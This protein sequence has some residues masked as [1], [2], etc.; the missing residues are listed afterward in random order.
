MPEIA[1]PKELFLHELG[2]IL[3]VERALAEK[4][5]PKLIGEVQDSEFKSGL[6]KH[7][8]QTRKHVKN[9]EQVFRSLDEEPK[10]ETCIGF[11]GLKKEHEKLIEESSSSLVDLID[12][13]AAARTENYEIAAYEALR[14]MAKAM[15]ED[16]A[17]DLL[18][19]NLQDEKE[20]LREVEKIATRV[21]NEMVKQLTPA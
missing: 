5:L 21:S 15:G 12:L 4:T 8:E 7:L 17:V 9:V 10:A 19:A 2:D 16:K 13:G 18:D 14:R 20:T 11:E 6:E 1:N 3:Y